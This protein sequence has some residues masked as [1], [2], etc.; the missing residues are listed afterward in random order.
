M[1]FLHDAFPL[2][3]GWLCCA[4][5]AMTVEQLRMR[6][7]QRIFFGNVGDETLTQVTISRER[8]RRP[9]KAPLKGPAQENSW[10]S[11]FLCDPRVLFDAIALL[12]WL[13]LSPVPT[14]T[15]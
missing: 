4:G 13:S 8:Q 12:P 2:R 11:A 5:A 7:C 14:P 6:K 15:R 10:I 3:E 1:F 9:Y